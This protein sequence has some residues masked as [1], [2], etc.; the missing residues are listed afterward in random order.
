MD[1]P[2]ARSKKT[3]WVLELTKSREEP[4]IPQLK[5]LFLHLN[6]IGIVTPQPNPTINIITPQSNPPI[7]II[8]PQANP[9]I[10]IVTPQPNPPINM[11][12]S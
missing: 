2:R 12:T 10:D 1:Q 7:Y 11:V 6:Q 4:E 9:P 8:T 5:L 3:H